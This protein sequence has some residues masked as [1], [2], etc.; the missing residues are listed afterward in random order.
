MA[1]GLQQARTL[2]P[3]LPWQALRS[4]ALS[5]QGGCWG[6]PAG[7]NRGQAAGRGEQC[8]AS[9]AGA[10]KVTSRHALLVGLDGPT[11]V[12]GQAILQPYYRQHVCRAGPVLQALSHA[13]AATACRSHLNHASMP[14]QAC[15]DVFKHV[16]SCRI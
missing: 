6:E 15:K 10:Q 14:A 3:F 1:A 7:G 2:L 12:N 13:D 9:Q 8:M 11:Y 4:A 5:R 16:G